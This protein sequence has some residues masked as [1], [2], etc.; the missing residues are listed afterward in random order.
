MEDRNGASI[1]GRWA[2]EEK[3]RSWR[4]QAHLSAGAEL[5]SQDCEVCV[6]RALRLKCGNR[7]NGET[8][9]RLIPPKGT[10]AY[11]FL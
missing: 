8:T 2:E 7:N 9:I 11:A 10:S 6:S 4:R 3:D 1:R 5:L